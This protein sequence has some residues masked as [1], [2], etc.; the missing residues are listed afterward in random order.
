MVAMVAAVDCGV[1][2]VY[3][4][5]DHCT[6]AFQEKGEGLPGTTLLTRVE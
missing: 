3:G 2:D 1:Y 4:L 5:V 6:V